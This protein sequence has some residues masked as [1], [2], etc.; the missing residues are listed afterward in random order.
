MCFKKLYYTFLTVKNNFYLFKFNDV[1][2]CLL[3]TLERLMEEIK[4]IIIEFNKNK[5]SKIVEDYINNNNLTETQFYLLSAEAIKLTPENKT[6]IEAV[7]NLIILI[8][9]QNEI[10]FPK[11]TKYIKEWKKDNTKS[12]LFIETSPE[13][14]VYSCEAV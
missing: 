7:Q 1:I 10:S 2:E 3:I 4:N 11:Y 5:N 12:S 9:K 6:P 13:H 14:S 8:L